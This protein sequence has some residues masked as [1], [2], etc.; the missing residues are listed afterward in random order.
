MLAGTE[1]TM[2]SNNEFALS[3]Y[4]VPWAGTICWAMCF[5]P[6]SPNIS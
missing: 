6:D 3:G 4:I 5:H 1:R 2:V